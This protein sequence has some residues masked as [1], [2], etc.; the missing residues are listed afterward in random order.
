MT[1][2]VLDDMEPMLNFHAHTGFQMLQLFE[3]APQLVAWRSL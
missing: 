1:E 2:R 3:Y